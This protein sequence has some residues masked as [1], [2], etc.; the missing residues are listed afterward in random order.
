M[1]TKTQQ[2]LHI[3]FKN[4]DE[5]EKEGTDA[6]KKGKKLIQSKDELFFANPTVFERVFTPQKFRL[7]AIISALKPSSIYQ[8][9]QL[10][11]RNFANVSR[12]CY[13]LETF[14]FIHLKDSDL[15]ERLTKKPELVFPYEKIVVHL[16]KGIS[17]GYALA[18]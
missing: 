10:S 15:G 14:G 12:D 17:F 16:P 1:K 2:T 6:L 11:D 3:R 5:F 9:A 8:L 7:L 4:L 13:A 18:S